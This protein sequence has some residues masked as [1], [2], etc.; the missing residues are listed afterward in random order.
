LTPFERLGVPPEGCSSFHFPRLIGDAAAKK[1]LQEN[2]KVPAKDAKEINLVDKVVPH[3]QL[4]DTAQALAEKWVAEGKTK[5]TARGYE[6]FDKLRA[7]N[8]EESI[9]LSKAFMSYNFL[10]K[11]AEF[12]RS[13]GKTAPALVFKTAAL[14]RPLWTAL[15]L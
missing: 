7:V 13:K 12:L 4:L 10:N 9:A 11:Q 8:E 5:V 6:D 1:M 15:F 2:W 14:T 3:D